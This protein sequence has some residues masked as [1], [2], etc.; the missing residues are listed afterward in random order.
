MLE[1]FAGDLKARIKQLQGTQYKRLRSVALEALDVGQLDTA[2]DFGL[3]A[4]RERIR[5]VYHNVAQATNSE[6]VDGAL[7]GSKTAARSAK[8]AFLRLRGIRNWLAHSG[9]VSH[10][11]KEVI[12]TMRDHDSCREALRHDL[13]LLLPANKQQRF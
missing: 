1:V 8:N 6:E 9:N 5:S 13:E 10:P 11:R 3:D 2:A 7:L 12:A 4:A